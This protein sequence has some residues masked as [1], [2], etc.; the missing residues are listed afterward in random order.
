MARNNLPF[1][2]EKIKLIKIMNILA[3]IMANTLT[4]YLIVISTY[5][6]AS[7]SHC[8]ILEACPI[9]VPTNYILWKKPVSAPMARAGGKPLSSVIA[10][11]HKQ[12]V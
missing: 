12:T 1:G 5:G 9:E 6:I 2:E 11:K 8:N 3:E 4:R 10:V 7:I